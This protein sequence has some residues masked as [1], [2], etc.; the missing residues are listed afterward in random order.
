MRVQQEQIVLDVLLH[1]SQ[2]KRLPRIGWALRGVEQPESVADHTY[3]VAFIAMLLAD[4]DPGAVDRERVLRMALVHDLAESLVTDLPATLA[5]FLAPDTK[6]AVERAALA[7]IVAALPA[8]EEYVTLWEEYESGETP[9]A[10]LVHDAD[11]LEV[12]VQAFVYEQRGQRNLDEF[13]DG[14]SERT[15]ST[16]LAERLTVA[17]RE[18]RAALFRGG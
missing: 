11:K 14:L 13:W 15:L 7:E 1:A 6:H 5:R 16:P 9:E 10:R 17:L 3:G 18:R 12:V 8:P 2:L 4:L